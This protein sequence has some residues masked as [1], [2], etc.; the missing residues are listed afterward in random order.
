MSKI[1]IDTLVAAPVDT[2]WTRYTDPEHITQWNFANDDWCCPTASNDLRPGGRYIARM[3]AR[4]GS[5]G[6]DFGG[7]YES[8]TP[9]ESLAYTL[10]DGRL[11]QTSFMPEGTGT[12]VTTTF[13]AEGTNSEEM[14]RAGWQAILDNFRAHAEAA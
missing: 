12:R 3:E 6:F 4:D 2:V 5:M 11:V 7:T 8:V 9:K 10:D 1:T 14:Q 13:D